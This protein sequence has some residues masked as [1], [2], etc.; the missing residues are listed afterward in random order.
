[1][2]RDVCGKSIALRGGDMNTRLALLIVCPNS[3]RVCNFIG[4]VKD[5]EVGIKD[6]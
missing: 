6:G 4:L 3:L 1:M 5:P 2:L